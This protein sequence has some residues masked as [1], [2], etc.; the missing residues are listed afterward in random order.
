MPDPAVASIVVAAHDEAATI[1]RCLRALLADAEPGVEVVVVCN[2]CTD[3]TAA[4]AGAVGPPVTVVE[5]DEA[6]KTAALN[7]GDAAVNAFPRLYVDADVEVAPASRDALIAA[8]RGGALFATPPARLLTDHSDRWVQAY[9][10]VWASR[11]SVLAGQVGV[12][13]YALSEA[14]RARFAVFPDVINDDQFVHDRFTPE[15]RVQV[16][17]PPT[18]VR[19]PATFRALVDRRARVLLGNEQLAAR[20]DARGS[21]AGGREW[22]LGLA[23]S[24][25]Q[26]PDLVVFGVITLVARLRAA[27]QRRDG[28]AAWGRDATSR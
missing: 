9:Y 4:I 28:S 18:V 25:R 19:V 5:L 1:H 12:G 13:V 17:G 11:P 26:W 3:A 8:L 7:A 20:G 22:L 6:S 16:D 27:R 14:G 10:R 21:S 2:G 15:E 24:P 23:R